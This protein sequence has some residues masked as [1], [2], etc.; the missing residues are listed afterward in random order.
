M[1]TVAPPKGA[2]ILGADYR[3]L[4]VARSLGRRGVQ[5]WTLAE[6][7]EPLATVSRYAGR[8]IHW[9]RTDDNA[10]VAFL[11]D[12]AA[13]YGLKGWA[14]IP[15][16]D[17]AAA[18]LARHHDELAQHYIHTVPDWDAVRWAYDKRLTYELAQRVGVVHPRT[19]PAGKG[20]DPATVPITF[21]SVLKP[22]IKEQLNALTCAKAWRVD[23]RAQ[24]ARRYRQACELIDPE[25]LMLQELVIGGGEMQFSYAT[26]ARDG[27]PLASV[28]ARRTRQYPADFGRASTFVETVDCPDIIE[29][30]LR[31]LRE[32]RYTGLIEI[33][34]KRDSRD[35]VLKVLDMNPRVWGWHTLCGRA[36]VD[37]PWLLWLLVN[38]EEV[39]PL[40][41]RLGVGWLRLTTDTPTA[42]RELAARRL[43]IRD[44]ARSLRRPRESAIFAW[45][46]PLPG[47]AELPV[48][49]YV[50]TRRL[51]HG[52]TV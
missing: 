9:P 4:G 13:S 50:L 23:D 19:V 34:Y 22:A 16:S 18:M 36:G 6:R 1:G 25:L 3:A 29:P 15:S 11:R 27:V 31:L 8:T 39:P 24:L 49:A 7:G 33:E 38:G 32:L 14:L 2:L 42:L 41:A 40:E 30:S 5:V 48:L 12:L 21:P 47:L 45:D 43:G 51:L 20:F 44:Y 52:E 28:A 10:R 17:A 26:L 46:D 35:G 37:F